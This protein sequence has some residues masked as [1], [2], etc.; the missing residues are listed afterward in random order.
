MTKTYAGL[1]AEPP[2]S[3]GKGRIPLIILLQD[4]ASPSTQRI[5]HLVNLMKSS[6]H[7]KTL[8]V[9]LRSIGLKSIMHQVQLSLQN[10]I[11]TLKNADLDPHGPHRSTSRC[12]CRLA[13]ILLA[14][15]PQYHEDDLWKDQPEPGYMNEESQAHPGLESSQPAQS[16]TVPESQSRSPPYDL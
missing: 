4:S 2:Q 13:P 1:S 15:E 12:Q 9:E 5:H 7:R 16:L 8:L 11:V 3:S 10:P 6:N 14:G